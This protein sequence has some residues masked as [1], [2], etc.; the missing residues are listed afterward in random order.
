MDAGDIAHATPLPAASSRTTA[1]PV[2][3]LFTC[4]MDR[5]DTP[6]ARLHSLLSCSELQRAERFCSAVLARRYKVARAW[7]RV[8]LSEWTGTAPEMLAFRFGAAGKPFLDKPFLEEG[9]A[10]NVSHSE[11]ALLIGVTDHGRLGVDIEKQRPIEDHEQLARRYFS[12]AETAELLSLPGSERDRA[13]LRL[14]TR[15]EAFIKALGGG[16]SIP[17]H[18][19]SVSADSCAGNALYAADAALADPAQWFVGDVAAGPSLLAAVALDRPACSVSLS[20]DPD[21]PNRL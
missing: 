19:F 18:A 16:L 3:H 17:L 13:F 10:F 14:W 5:D 12:A 21:P 2:V 8:V 15:K 11:A 20:A 1:T 7:L 4:D 6:D 9:P